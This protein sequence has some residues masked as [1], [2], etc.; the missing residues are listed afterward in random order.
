VS[1]D[2]TPFWI[3]VP[4]ADL[5][6]LRERLNRTRWPEAATVEMLDNVM[7]Y[8]LPGT[9]ASSARLYW[10]S[11][12]KP[13]GGTVTVPVGC[14]IFPKEIFRPSRRWR[15]ASSRTSATGTSRPRR[16]LRRVRAA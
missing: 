4:E 9:G 3:D 11:L 10:E 1:D 8:W 16:P 2:I 5:D 14:S 13:I 7:M 6:D 15:N 12:R